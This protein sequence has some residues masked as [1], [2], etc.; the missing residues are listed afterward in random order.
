[1]DESVWPV[2]DR[3]VGPVYSG[4]SWVKMDG[5]GEGLKVDSL[6]KWT[7]LKSKSGLSKEKRLYD[8]KKWIW[9]V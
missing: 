3:F 4:Q 7:A 8:L 2:L 9:T 6:Q 1:M 5:P